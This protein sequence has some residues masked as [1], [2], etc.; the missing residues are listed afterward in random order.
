MSVRGCVVDTNRHGHVVSPPW[1]TH[2]PDAPAPRHKYVRASICASA[3]LSLQS[4]SSR[5]CSVGKAT[6]IATMIDIGLSGNVRLQVMTAGMT[7]SYVRKHVAHLLYVHRQTHAARHELVHFQTRDFHLEETHTEL[8][9]SAKVIY[10]SS[11]THRHR[12]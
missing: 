5:Q 6:T 7:A 8:P 10:R 2:V 1:C 3:G 4:R 9:P 12:T 11:S